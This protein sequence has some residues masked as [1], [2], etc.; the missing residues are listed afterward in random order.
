MTRKI[1]LLTLLLSMTTA[2]LL[3]M[4]GKKETTKETLSVAFHC[5]VVVQIY[6][7]YVPQLGINLVHN[8]LSY[9]CYKK[10][11]HKKKKI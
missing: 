9:F 4:V 1:V 8:M 6:D 5:S 3:G 2:P 10:K 11:Q 7:R